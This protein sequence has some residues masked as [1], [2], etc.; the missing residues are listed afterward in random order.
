MICLLP[1]CSYLSETSRMLE[2]YKA[3]RAGGVDAC[4]ATH[5]GV[6]ETAL[7]AAGVPYDIVGPQM[8]NERSARF[9]REGIGQGP[10]GQS[11]YSDAE[12]RAY[13]RAETAYFREHDIR[14]AVTGFTLTTLISTRVAGIRLAT[15][16]AG[17]WVPPVW[18]RRLL[19]LPS[20]RLPGLFS[21]L[22]RSWAHRLYNSGTPRLHYYLS[23]FHRIADEFGVV[24]PPSMAALLLSDLALVT[25]A[26]EV[27]GVSAVELSAWRPDG[28]RAYWPST[29]LRYSGP[30]YAHLDVPLP[31]EVD[32]FLTAPGSVVYVAITSSPPELVRGVVR[33]LEP[34][35]A[36]LLVAGTV[37]ALG[38][39]A[40][41]RV[42][43]GGVLPSH[44]IMSRVDAAVTAGGQGSVQTAMA[45]GA[46]L[47]GVP[48]QPEQDL[49]VVLLE[50]LGAARRI[51]PA[52]AVTPELATLVGEVLGDDSYR[53][54][55]KGVQQL[56]DGIDGAANAAA[57]VTA[58]AQR[59]G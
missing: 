15:E 52:R 27:L 22:P 31:S 46:P 7:K 57:E 38:D 50:R 12:L 47:V 8:S 6:H 4:I 42:L 10:V 39:L 48:L 5:G 13:V 18:E 41:D 19:P 56:Y 58:L 33:A 1:N 35:R 53:R 17:S 45:G 3:L 40:S 25:E 44:L 43:V 26:P 34:L 2:I 49:N 21:Y 23:G 30:L 28:K 51:A 24:P 9:V 37:H 55:A 36:R 16:H 11:M 54:A 14:V 20:M 29:R 32:E 59:K